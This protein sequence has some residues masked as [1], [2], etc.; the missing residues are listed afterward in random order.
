MLRMGEGRPLMCTGIF[1]LK[2]RP[3]LALN[4]DYDRTFRLT[5]EEGSGFCMRIRYGDVWGLP[6]G[7]SRNGRSA[8]IQLAP[9]KEKAAYD[10][11]AQN[12]TDLP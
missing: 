5:L 8:N 3:I 12:R 2:P 4:F 6:L 11:E 7:V 10:P 1:L 9:F